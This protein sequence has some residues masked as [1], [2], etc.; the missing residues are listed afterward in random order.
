MAKRIKRRVK[1]RFFVL[2]GLVFIIL[3]ILI[4]KNLNFNKIINP[5]ISV[6]GQEVTSA[7]GTKKEFTIC[8]DPGH[9]GYDSGT[10]SPSGVMEKDINLKVTL[11][12]GKILEKGSFKIIYTRTSDDM[13]GVT[14]KEDL[15]LR[16]DTSNNANSDIFVSLHCNFDKLSPKTQGTEIWCRFPNES[17]GKLASNIQKQLSESGYT[18][19]RGI[20]YEADGGLYVLKNTN[21]VAVLFE[22]GFLSNTHDCNFLK[23]EK[24]QDKCAKAIAQ[25]I[26]DYANDR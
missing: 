2:I 19:D 24:G 23:S 1:K 3:L 13:M 25:A 8:L 14:Q 9:G 20:K 21:A 5:N 16:C 6:N 26:I 22:L 18:K 17:G 10:I 11:K 12:L 7:S 4:V 15:Q